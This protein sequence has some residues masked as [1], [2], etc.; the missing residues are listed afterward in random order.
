MDPRPPIN[1]KDNMDSIE[2]RTFEIERVMKAHWMHDLNEW[3]L[4]HQTEEK[5][6]S[7]LE[8]IKELILKSVPEARA[9]IDSELDSLRT[10][11][12]TLELRDALKKIIRTMARIMAM[13]VSLEELERR[14]YK[15]S[16]EKGLIPLSRGL[17]YEISERDYS[18]ALHIPIVFF[19]S[20]EMFE[21]SFVEG[22]QVLARKITTDPRLK[23]ISKIEGHS[24]LVDKNFRF[25]RNKGFTLIEDIIDDASGGAIMTRK[26]L[27]E[28]YGDK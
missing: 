10:V 18:V 24:H 1:L 22:L 19:E 6:D 2:R 21:Q 9:I 16:I 7:L 27:L 5:I 3:D 23:N 28:I 17:M 11:F 25:F 15:K 12:R 26:K 14:D 8:E 4:E 13:S 20:A